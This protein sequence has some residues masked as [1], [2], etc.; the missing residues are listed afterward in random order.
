M[1]EN[2]PYVKDELLR[3][4]LENA[5]LKRLLTS[6]GIV[7]EEPPN[8]ETPHAVNEPAPEVQ[9]AISEKIALFRRLFRGRVDVYPL[10][11]DSV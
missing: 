5:W 8:A 7:W 6:H 2:T 10:R 9:L 4:R 11:L 1:V 3:L